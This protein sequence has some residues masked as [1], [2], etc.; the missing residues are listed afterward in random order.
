MPFS[1][2]LDPSLITEVEEEYK[3]AAFWLPFSA[4]Q[5]K[6]VFN[7]EQLDELSN[8]IKEFQEAGYSNRKKEKAIEKYSN[9]SLKLL[10]LAKV[11]V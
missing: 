7:Q 2:D 10:K 8:F 4:I 5:L 11:M 6:K 1:D 9:V 3:K